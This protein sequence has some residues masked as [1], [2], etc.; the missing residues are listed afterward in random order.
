MRSSSRRCWRGWRSGAAVTHPAEQPRR[1]AAPYLTG[2]NPRPLQNDRIGRDDR[3]IAD[4][5]AG[6]QQRACADRDIVSDCNR[7]VRQRRPF[8]HMRYQ[9]CGLS[10][11]AVGPDRHEHG[12]EHD[13]RAMCIGAHARAKRQIDQ[14]HQRNRDQ[15]AMEQ[16][17]EQKQIGQDVHLVP[18][19]LARPGFDGPR[20]QRREG[21]QGS[22]RRNRIQ[23][24]QENRCAGDDDAPEVAE[25]RQQSRAMPGA[26]QRSRQHHTG[27]QCEPSYRRP[28]HP[29]HRAAA[30][31]R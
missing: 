8:D 2:A 9:Q 3:A 27:Q 28:P 23:V 5:Y 12:V 7:I 4:C 14:A 24:G 11:Q 15:T 21:Q 31:S 6:Q 1:N 30:I 16:R 20:M 17:I 26:G 10:Q 18:E 25:P 22:Q 29:A 19:L 13:A